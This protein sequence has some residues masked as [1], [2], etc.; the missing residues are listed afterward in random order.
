[1]V[2]LVAGAVLERSSATIA[3]QIG[4]SGVL[5][6]ATVQAAAT[7]LPKVSTRLASVKF[8]D[9]QLAVS[10]IFGG[11]AFLPVIFLLARPISGAAVLPNA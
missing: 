6:G 2:T 5:F 9:Y 8:K 11:N 3:T 4:M 10:E 7:S 1:L